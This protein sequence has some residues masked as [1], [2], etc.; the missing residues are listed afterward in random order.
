MRR[1]LLVH[2]AV[3]VIPSKIPSVYYATRPSKSLGMWWPALNH[4]SLNKKAVA[5]A[6][7]LKITAINADASNFSFDI[8]G[9]V[10]GKDGSGTNQAKFVS[11][12]GIITILPRDFTMIRTYKYAKK[13]YPVGFEIK[14]T[15]KGKFI[16][17]WKPKK[18]KN[19]NYENSYILAQG[20]KNSKHTLEI[21]PNGDGLIA[22]KAI[23]VYTPP[24]K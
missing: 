24:L 18:L 7:T 1:R 10:T 5:E 17:V 23:R 20:L 4:V 14:W 16:D 11:N 3:L 9:S 21:I 19:S 12:S 15:V 13:K 2:K 6:W 22:I 8:A